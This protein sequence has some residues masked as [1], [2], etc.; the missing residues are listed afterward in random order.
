[1]LNILQIAEIIVICLQIG[2]KLSE[3][4]YVTL[5]NVFN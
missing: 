1:M 3:A 2:A 5:Y 4:L